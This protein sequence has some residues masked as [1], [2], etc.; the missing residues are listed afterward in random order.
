MVVELHLLILVVKLEVTVCSPCVCHFT[1][2]CRLR[3]AVVATEALTIY[4]VVAR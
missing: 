3:R 4:I 1:G 2:L